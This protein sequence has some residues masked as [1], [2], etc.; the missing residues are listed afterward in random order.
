MVLPAKGS[1]AR[2]ALVKI[3]RLRALV[4]HLFP[5][6][7]EEARSLLVAGVMRQKPEGLSESPET[8]LQLAACVGEKEGQHFHELKKAALEELEVRAEQEK[9][10]AKHAKRFK[11]PTPK[12]PA[13]PAPA[14]GEEPPGPTAGTA[15]APATPREVAAKTKAPPEFVS[16]LPNVPYL[17]LKWQPQHRRAS[18]EFARTLSHSKPFILFG[19]R[20][21]KAD[22]SNPVHITA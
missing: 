1:G 13:T 21:K 9:Q 8:L 5:N 16:L 17:Y 3:D 12:Q 10:N 4:D 6:E 22:T 20:K 2:G 19:L 18:V 15:R 14:T 7:S 11:E